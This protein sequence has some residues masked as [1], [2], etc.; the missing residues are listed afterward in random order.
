MISQPPYHSATLHVALVCFAVDI[1]RATGCVV[2]E[3]CILLFSAY[4][5]PAIQQPRL[6]G[7]T[8]TEISSYTPLSLWVPSAIGLYVATVHTQCVL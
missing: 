8:R 6:H 1:P 7:P 2:S 4:V 3:P 5:R